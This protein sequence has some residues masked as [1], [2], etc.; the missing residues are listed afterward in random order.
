M[1]IKIDANSKRENTASTKIVCILIQAKTTLTL[2]YFNNTTLALPLLLLGQRVFNCRSFV[3]DTPLPCLKKIEK[4]ITYNE[5][6]KSDS[7]VFKIGACIQ[8]LAHICYSLD[9]SRIYLH[10][11]IS[12][13]EHVLQF[14][15]RIS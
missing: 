2:M 5:V 7:I 13:T 1:A 4:R 3:R 6:Y 12:P 14:W 11:F 8:S 10:E 9:K 15:D